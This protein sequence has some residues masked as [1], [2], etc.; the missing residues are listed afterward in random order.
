MSQHLTEEEQIETIKRW[1]AEN[2]RALL[3]GIV[4]ALGVYFGWEAW[5]NQRQQAQETAS[6]LYEDLLE[7]VVA[8]EPG[9]SLSSEQVTKAKSIVEEIKNEH[10]GS[11]YAV[12]AAL[13]L[14]KVAI[15][16]DDLALAESELRWASDKGDEILSPLAQ[17]RLAKVLYGQ[18]KYDE[19]LSELD[20]LSSEAYAANVAELKG[21]IRSAQGRPE[22]AR[23]A[24]QLALDELLPAQSNMR[25]IIQMKLDDVG[26]AP[27]AAQPAEQ[28]AES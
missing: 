4:L 21:D 2:G 12:Q 5:Q 7:T 26:G 25:D 15:E 17:L 3:I 20:K 19:A 28:G 11:L 18:E 10:G 24:Y 6:I 27:A 16:Q 22:E 23:V 8:Q 14:A 13:F 1:W 9:Q